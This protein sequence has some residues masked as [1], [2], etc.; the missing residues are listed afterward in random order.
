MCKHLIL[1]VVH[2]TVEAADG[3]EFGASFRLTAVANSGGGSA[4]SE[5]FGKK[6][7]IAVEV[8]VFVG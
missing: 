8:K 1:V 5:G 7:T 4:H 3:V 2:V 6:D